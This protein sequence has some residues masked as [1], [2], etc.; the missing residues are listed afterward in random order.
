MRKILIVDD[1]EFACD[2]YSDALQKAGYLV[3]TASD[4]IKGLS[5]ATSEI[6]DLILLDVAMP[7][8]DG[9]EF[10]KKAASDPFIQKVPIV[11]LTNIRNDQTIK[12]AMEN[13]AL[14]YLIKPALT[15]L[16]VADEVNKFL[17]TSTAT[18][19]K[20]A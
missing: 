16:Q 12:E 17:G 18:S 14:G 20:P 3:F 5:K 6:P 11:L 4:G 2:L 15:P 8:M 19:N 1:D 7:G 10:T 9:L 13:G